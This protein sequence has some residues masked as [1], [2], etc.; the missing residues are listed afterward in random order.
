MAVHMSGWR[1]LATTMI[2]HEECALVSQLESVRVTSAAVYTPN[3]SRMCLSLVHWSLRIA[4]VFLLDLQAFS[5]KHEQDQT[6]ARSH[7]LK[8]PSSS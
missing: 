2:Q 8:T 3:Q 6:V 1:N 4:S 7:L 5:R